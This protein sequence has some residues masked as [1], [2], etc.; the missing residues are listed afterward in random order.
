MTKQNISNKQ[1][2]PKTQIIIFF[3]KKGSTTW[4]KFQ[5][6]I[7]LSLSP[8]VVYV[9][10]KYLRILFRVTSAKDTEALLLVYRHTIE[11]KQNFLLKF[12]R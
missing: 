6:K 2:N 7:Q 10:M 3:L 12:I 5:H 9:S 1:T 4:G 11:T 8:H